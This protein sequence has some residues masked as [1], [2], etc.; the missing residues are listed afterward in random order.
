MISYCFSSKKNPR[1]NNFCT[2]TYFTFHLLLLF[3]G[4]LFFFYSSSFINLFAPFLRC[5]RHFFQLQWSFESKAL[6]WRYVFI[7]FHSRFFLFAFLPL[8][9]FCCIALKAFFRLVSQMTS[10]SRY[11]EK[12]SAPHMATPSIMDSIM[13]AL[14]MVL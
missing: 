3:V 7:L 12:K 4:V 9:V 2:C 1:R 5:K 14:T 6:Q 8:L 10:I 13:F 11:M